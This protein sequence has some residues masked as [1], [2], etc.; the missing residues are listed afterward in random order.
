MR[1]LHT[2]IRVLD[3]EKSIDFYVNKLGLTITGQREYENGRFTL[4]FLKSNDSDVW[5]MKKDIFL[6]YLSINEVR[7]WETK[8]VL[9]LQNK[10]VLKY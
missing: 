1:F 9:L 5:E 8:K 6:L 2:M 4:T 3:L 10:D 7:L